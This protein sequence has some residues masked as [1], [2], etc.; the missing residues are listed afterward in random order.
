MR[1]VVELYEPAAEELGVD[2]RSSRRP[3]RSTVEG[4]RELIGQA[5]SNIV[6]NAIKYSA[7][8]SDKPASA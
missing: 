6:D 3:A 2:A 4:N 8:A 5:L 1:D 7:D